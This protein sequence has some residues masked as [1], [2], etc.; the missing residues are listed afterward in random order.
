MLYQ[1]SIVRIIRLFHEPEF[2]NGWGVN[3]RPP[4]I[5]DEGTI[6]EILGSSGSPF[7]DHY[8]VECSNQDGITVWLAEFILEELDELTI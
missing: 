3:Q 4:Q 5:G 2:Y 1:Y 7:P 8:I 6:V